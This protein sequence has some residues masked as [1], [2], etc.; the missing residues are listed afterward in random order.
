M[1]SK[2]YN[3]KAQYSSYHVILFLFKCNIGIFGYNN[4][5]YSGY[6]MMLTKVFQKFKLS[7]NSKK[8]GRGGLNIKK[9]L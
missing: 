1:D 2:V 9:C 6:G 3:L 4:N 7:P 8:I 5:Y